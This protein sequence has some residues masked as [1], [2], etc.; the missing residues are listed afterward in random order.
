VISHSV[1]V[2]D[3]VGRF[4]GEEFVVLLPG[5]GASGI[6]EVA[7]RVRAA[8]TRLAVPVGDNRISG[9]SVSVGTA[10]YPAAGRTLDRLIH[11]ADT[12]L[13]HAKRTGRNRVSHADDIS[14]GASR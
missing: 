8:V 4:G 12:A 7:E 5:I 3:C 2:E 10:A 6:A 1:R 9:L 13:L 11:S 14:A